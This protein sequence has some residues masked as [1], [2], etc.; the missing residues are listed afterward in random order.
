M[1]AR[2]YDVSRGRITID[3]VDIRNLSFQALTGLV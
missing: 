3:S 1:T 2:L